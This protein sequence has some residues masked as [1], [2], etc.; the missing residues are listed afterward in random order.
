VITQERLRE[1]LD[2]DSSTGLFTWRQ[3]RGGWGAGRVAGN[4]QWDGY[5]RIGL[6]GCQ[7]PAHQLAW[8]WV[9]G[10]WPS[11]QL[12][13]VNRDRSDNRITNLRESSQSQN[14]A[15]T[16]L[17]YN[18]TSG[19]KGVSKVRA[20]GKWLATIKVMGKSK[21]LGTYE[22]PEEAHESYMAALRATHGDFARAS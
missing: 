20:S 7:F 3:S 6:D 12:D 5:V 15:N 17:R 1:L 18:N 9:H 16:T 22:T 4:L 14:L 19:Y 13:H 8:L 10:S 2:Y 21:Y 11:Q